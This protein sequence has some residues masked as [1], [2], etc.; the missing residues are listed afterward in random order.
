L[1]ESVKQAKNFTSLSSGDL[2]NNRKF[3]LLGDPAMRLAFPELRLRI[4]GINGSPI[5]G[6][7]T[8][9]ALQKYTFNGI[10]TDG[11]GNPVT[12][13]NGTVH[14]TVYDK[15]QVVKTLGNDPSSIVTGFNQQSSVL[16]KGNATVTDGKFSFTFIVPK[17][18]NYQTGRGRIS[19]Y[20][21]NG[22]TDANGVNT[23]FYVGGTAMPS[24]QIISAR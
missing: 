4:T 2:L 14:P 6:S 5:T 1:G 13:F 8:L 19:L 18:I 12:N 9:R 20:A 24:L 10:V 22:I 23:S 21:D 3:T 7:D 11:A 16:Y 17:D 15:S